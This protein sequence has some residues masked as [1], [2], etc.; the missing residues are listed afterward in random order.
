V[1]LCIPGKTPQVIQKTNKLYT[2]IIQ[3]LKNQDFD[4]VERL[5]SPEEIKHYVNNVENSLALVDGKEVTGRLGELIQQH[6]AQ[7]LPA[8]YL[9]NF[10]RNVQRNVSFRVVNQLFGFIE[11]SMASGGFT[12]TNEGNIIAYKKVTSDFKDIHTGTF[13]NSP[14]KVVEVPRNT[15]NEDPEQTCSEGLHFAALSYLKYYADNNYTNKV[16][17]VEVDPADVVAIPTDY[18][19]A[20]ARCCKY[21]VIAE[22]TGK[23]DTD[24][25]DDKESVVDTGSEDVSVDVKVSTD[26]GKTFQEVVEGVLNNL[27]DDEDKKAITVQ[28]LIN[29]VRGY[30]ESR[31]RRQLE[32]NKLAELRELHYMI[33]EHCHLPVI[34]PSKFRDKDTAIDRIVRLIK[35]G[36]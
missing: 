17:V 31:A 15:V 24:E 35:Q 29:D 4:E 33:C 16:V 27:L 11:A 36:Y 2:P 1:S 20:K 12:I 8:D 30:H 10:F 7:G 23:Y 22:Y 13:D 3:A 28:D 25:Y 32:Q 19:N 6:Y 14:G 18:N 21:K 34:T 5:M 9:V 26:S